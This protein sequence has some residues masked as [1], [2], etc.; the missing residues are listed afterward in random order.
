MTTKPPSKSEQLKA[1][2]VGKFFARPATYGLAVFRIDKVSEHDTLSAR[3][4]Y[5]RAVGYTQAMGTPARPG[6]YSYESFNPQEVFSTA[7]EA[8]SAL[9]HNARVAVEERQKALDAAKKNLAD[10]EALAPT[11]GFT[12]E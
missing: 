1:S 7:A 8:K 9:V 10:C 11:K 5:A 3:T 6:V 4:T 12:H 2:L